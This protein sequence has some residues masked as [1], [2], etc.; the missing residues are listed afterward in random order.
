[1]KMDFA[2]MNLRLDNISRR[3]DRVERRLELA[4]DALPRDYRLE[5]AEIEYRAP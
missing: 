4:D 3:L 5:L 2:A 1:M